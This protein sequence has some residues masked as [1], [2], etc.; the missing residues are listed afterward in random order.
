MVYLCVGGVLVFAG[1]GTSYF[2]AAHTGDQGGIAAY[3]FQLA[4]IAAYI[5][6]SVV[7]VG[8]NWYLLLRNSSA[9]NN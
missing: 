6:M 9:K 4:V 2:F 7:L 8:L 1:S 3:F 5:L